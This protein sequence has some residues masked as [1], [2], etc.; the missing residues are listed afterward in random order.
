M[1]CAADDFDDDCW[2]P[3]ADDCDH[4]DYE[5]DILTGQAWCWRCGERWVLT[6]DEI[7]RQ[8]RFEAEYADEIWWFAFWM[9]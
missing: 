8:E 1:T 9:S 3:D 4:A 6:D 7:A 2:E 5:A